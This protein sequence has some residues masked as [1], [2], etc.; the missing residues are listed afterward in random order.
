MQFFFFLLCFVF[1]GWLHFQTPASYTS[2]KVRD[3][4]CSRANTVRKTVEEKMKSACSSADA[5]NL[6]ADLALSVSYDQVPPQPNEALDK[7]PKESLKKSD[8]ERVFSSANQES[9][10]HALLRT[11]AAKAIQPLKSSS[12]P[13]LTDSELIDL[14]SKEHNYS[15]PPSSC[16]LLDLPGTTFQVQPLSGTTGLLNHHQTVHGNGVKT[17]HQSVIHDDTSEHSK[18]SEYLHRHKQKFRHSRTFVIKDSSIEVTR[19]WEE[20]YDFNLDS[21]FTSDPKN[22]GIIRALHGYGICAT[23]KI[24][25]FDLISVLYFLVVVNLTFFLWIYH[26][27]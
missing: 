18:T 9:V 10:L 17:L 1:T 3:N 2:E 15:L 21:K 24:Y 6:L 4:D 12:S 20:N 7:N 22:R 26:F 13:P 11:P 23:F 14:M 16:L 25:I 5:L 27:Q 19:K 8:L